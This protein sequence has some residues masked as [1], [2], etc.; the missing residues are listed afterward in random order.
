M[1]IRTHGGLLRMC[2]LGGTYIPA[3]ILEDLEPIKV[4]AFSSFAYIFRLALAVS[5]IG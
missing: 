4:V 2:Q 5:F 1:P 3:K